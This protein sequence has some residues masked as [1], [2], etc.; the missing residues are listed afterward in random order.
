E[1]PELAQLPEAVLLDEAVAEDRDLPVRRAGRLVA[2]HAELDAAA[3]GLAAAGQHLDDRV[4][5][6]PVVELAVLQAGRAHALERAADAVAAAEHADAVDLDDAVGR[7][8]IDDVVPHLAVDVI[9]VGVLQ[10]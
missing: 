8:E 1:E 10:V 9:A 5:D 2:E 4:E 3:H 6:R 7:K